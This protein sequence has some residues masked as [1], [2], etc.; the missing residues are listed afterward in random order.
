MTYN[1]RIGKGGGEWNNDPQKVDLKPVAELIAIQRPD[2]VGVQEVDRFRERTAQMDQP[3]KL[4]EQLRM[5]W[6]FQP[7][8]TV[9]VGTRPDEQYGI[10]VLSRF[11]LQSGERFRLFKPDYSKSFPQY[12]DYYSEQRALLHT[13]VSVAGRTVHLFVTHLGLTVDQRER[14]IA[15]ILGITSRFPGPKIL[16]GDF[17]AP[18]KEPAMKLLSLAFHD[19][20]TAAGTTAEQRKSYPAGDTP[21]EAIDYIFVSHEFRVS[22]SRVIRDATLASDHNPVIAEVEL[23]K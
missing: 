12:P 5:T 19:T 20:L 6:A 14:Q 17:N 8:Y 10:G 2:I 21:R 15:E 18:P 1:I 4:A 13:T 9:A 22:S 7:A 16:M 11:P 23:L 3:V